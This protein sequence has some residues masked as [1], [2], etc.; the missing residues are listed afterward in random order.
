MVGERSGKTR[1][2]DEHDGAGADLSDAPEEVAVGEAQRIQ[3]PR[4]FPCRCRH[5]ARQQFLEI[6]MEQFALMGPPSLDI[7]NGCQ[8]VADVSCRAERPAN[9]AS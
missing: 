6:V 3:L 1:D 4:F 5:S 2:M 9:R 7:E 8:V